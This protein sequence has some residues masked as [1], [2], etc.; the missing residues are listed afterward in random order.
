[1][2]KVQSVTLDSTGKLVIAMI[3]TESASASSAPFAMT[4]SPNR[5]VYYYNGDSVAIDTVPGILSSSHSMSD[6]T[7]NE[8][9]DAIVE[10]IPPAKADSVRQS[11]MN[12]NNQVDTENWFSY[13]PTKADEDEIKKMY[14]VMLEQIDKMRAGTSGASA[15][16]KLAKYFFK[17]HILLKG[18]KGGFLHIATIAA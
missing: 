1:M 6:A 9:I 5:N 8:H 15:D 2:N 17:K 10:G 12:S 3:L 13:T 4:T 18:E 11:I 16:G 7:I 14:D